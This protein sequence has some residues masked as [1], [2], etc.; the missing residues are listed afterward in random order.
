MIHNEGKNVLTCPG[1]VL[2][3]GIT[4]PETKDD[5]NVVHSIK[6]AIPGN[7]AEKAELEQLATQTLQASAFKGQ[8]PAG[9]EWPVREI[10]MTKFT[11]PEDQQRLRGCVAINANTRLGAPGVFDVNGQQLSAMQYGRSLYAGASVALLVHCY[12]FN[13]KSKGLAFGLDGIQIVDDTAPALSV[14]GGMSPSEAA[15]IFGGGAPMQQPPVQQP[16]VQQPPVPQQAATP[17][18]PVVPDPSFAANA[19]GQGSVMTAKAGG[20][21]Y[22]AFIDQGWT[23]DQLV[24][25][26]YVQG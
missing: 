18:P 8:F 5:G 12:A 17:P 2:W 15:A 6:I 13:N 1:V 7:S 4:R 16:P 26:G 9:G 25:H 24:A 11:A 10:D 19:A 20:T 3:D 21:P 22:Q 23:H 14:G